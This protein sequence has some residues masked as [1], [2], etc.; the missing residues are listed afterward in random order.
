LGGIS[1]TNLR[2]TTSAA[3]ALEKTEKKD[4]QEEGLKKTV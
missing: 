2:R 3:V 4:L 1:G